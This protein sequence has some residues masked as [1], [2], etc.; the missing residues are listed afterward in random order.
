MVVD[1]YSTYFK[2]NVAYMVIVGDISTDRARQLMDLYF[3]AWEPGD[4]P[5]HSYETPE[6]PPAN[7]VAFADRTGAVQSVISVSY[8]L[9]LQPGDPDAIKVSVMNSILGGGVFSGRLM[10]NLREDKGF[11]YGARSSLSSDRLV[12][13]LNVR[14]EVRN[15]VTDSAIV[16]ILYEMD[17][18]VSEPV[19]EE[20]LELI[21]NYLNGSFA[22]S[23]ES[24]RTIARFAL[25]IERYNLPEDY[26]DTYLE[27]LS[28]VTATEVQQVA[29]TFIR[30]EN[31]FIIVGGNE[32]EVAGTLEKFS[33][34]GKVHFFDPF[35]RKIEEDDAE[36]TKTPVTQ[37]GFEPSEEPT[38]LQ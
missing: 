36:V 37:P 8:P 14:T 4:V 16:E 3:S 26:Y 24:P 1:Y 15:S 33:A 38:G 25:N 10:Q 31:S 2:P 20:T 17:R 11:T 6:P 32:S 27:R 35:G 30:P 7:T 13:R 12:G 23:L 18:M 5:S 34:D 29:G 19:D 9:F 22:R 28:R 21:K